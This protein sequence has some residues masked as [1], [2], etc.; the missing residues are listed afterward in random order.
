MILFKDS[1]NF[2]SDLRIATFDILELSLDSEVSVDVLRFTTKLKA[3]IDF[4]FCYPNCSIDLNRQRWSFS[5][6]IFL[7]SEIVVRLAESTDETEM[8]RLLQLVLGCAVSCD[9]KQFYIEHIIFMEESIQHVLMNAIQEVKRSI[10]FQRWKHFRNMFVFLVEQL[11]VKENRK[12][13]EEYSELGDQVR[14][15]KIDRWIRT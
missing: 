3:R 10:D 14:R 1:D 2:V 7:R 8:S 5:L 13:N 15:N 6:L 4:G 12:I 9:R 11:M